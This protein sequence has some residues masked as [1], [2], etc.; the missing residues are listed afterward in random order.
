[1]I[2]PTLHTTRLTLRA[3]KAS[4]A[5]PL[6]AFLA[7][8]R[9]EWIGG[10]WPGNDAADWLDHGR[11]MWAEHGRGSWIVALA[12]DTPIG[13]AGL[14]EHEGWPEPELGW[15][16]FDAFDGHGYAQ[17]AAIAA[18]NHANGPLGLPP[19]FSFIEPANVRSRA[20]AERLGAAFESNARFMDHDFHIY[21]H[22][23]GAAA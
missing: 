8:A 5:A 20:L 7:S 15:F 14:L 17:E 16:L 19:L 22:P 13:R 2:A 23:I 6:G 18:R 3:A 12:D 11:Q 21:R 10:P 1:M 9:A 4:D